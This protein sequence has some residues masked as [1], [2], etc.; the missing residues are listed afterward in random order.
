MGDLYNVG[1]TGEHFTRDLH[2]DF[3]LL[4]KAVT[5]VGLMYFGARQ[6]TGAWTS[7]MQRLAEHERCGVGR[8]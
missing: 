2:P 5:G 7:L 6:L 1:R 3:H 8:F 4:F